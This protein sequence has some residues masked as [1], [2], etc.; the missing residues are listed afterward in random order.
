MLLVTSLGPG[1]SGPRV[2]VTAT[3]HDVPL[4]QVIPASHTPQICEADSVGPPHSSQT[5]VYGARSVDI[6]SS[7]MT[8][9]L[10]S[11][12]VVKCLGHGLFDW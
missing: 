12:G 4:L 2:A 7:G 10:R 5:Y 6:G 8:G 11:A 3:R 1:S 9:A